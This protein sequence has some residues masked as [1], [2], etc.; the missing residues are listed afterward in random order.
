M[1]INIRAHFDFFQRLCA[2]VLPVCGLFLLIF[3]AH[4]TVI[5]HLT[6][7]REARSD[8]DK[9]ESCIAGGS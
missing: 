5:Q 8:F 9:V 2:L 6:N 4:L 1:H 3:K 7:R